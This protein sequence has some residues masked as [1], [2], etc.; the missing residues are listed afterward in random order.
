M[1]LIGGDG[2]TELRQDICVDDAGEGLTVDE[3][4]VTIED[5]EIEA[6]RN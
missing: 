4:A 5:D 3:H 6:R 1:H 2:I